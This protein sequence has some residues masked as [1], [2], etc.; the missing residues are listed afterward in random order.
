ME[1]K[2]EIRNFPTESLEIHEMALLRGIKYKTDVVEVFTGV[3]F[4]SEVIKGAA[5][6]RGLIN[7]FKTN[8]LVIWKPFS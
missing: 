6:C 4:Q 5:I 2:L 8:V 1:H 7:P 3:A